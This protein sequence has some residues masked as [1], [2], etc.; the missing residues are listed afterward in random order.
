MAIV[1]ISIMS[2]VLLTLIGILAAA[3]SATDGDIRKSWIFPMDCRSGNAAIANVMLHL[4]IN[5]LSTAVL[6]SSNFFMQVLNAPSRQEVYAAHAQGYWVDIGIPS[7]WNVFNLSNFKSL[8]WFSLLL[9][10]LPIHML[11]NS[12]VFRI[13]DYAGDFHVTI[14]TESFLEGGSYYLPGASL[15]MRDNYPLHVDKQVNVSRAATQGSKWERLGAAECREIYSDACSGL[16]DYRNV[17][18]IAKGQGW[19]R[20]DLW[21]LPAKGDFGSLSCPEAS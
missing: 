17:V 1:N 18:L 19:R 21:D 7:L 14:A 20:S 16:R 15:R 11:F 8:A 6:A 3:V 13:D 10:S 5:I 2:T 9:T 12:S 4:F